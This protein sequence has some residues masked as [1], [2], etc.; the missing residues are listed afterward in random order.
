[1]AGNVGRIADR[2]LQP[3]NDLPVPHELVDEISTCQANTRQSRSTHGVRTSWVTAS[4]RHLFSQFVIDNKN[5]SKASDLLSSATCIIA[6]AIRHLILDRGPSRRHSKI[7]LRPATFATH[8]KP[9]KWGTRCRVPVSADV[10]AGRGVMTKQD[11]LASIHSGQ[12]HLL[13]TSTTVSKPARSQWAM[14]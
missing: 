14:K 9:G 5:G 8:V 13:N 10:C 1:V 3:R 11:T 6:L 12:W 4:R 2:C 7:I